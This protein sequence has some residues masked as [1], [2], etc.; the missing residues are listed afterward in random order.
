[1]FERADRPR[2]F[3]LPPGADFPRHLVDGLLERT[4]G[5]PPEVLGRTT[6]IVNTRR[7]ARRIRSLFDA[8]PALLLP[9]IRLV[10]DLGETFALG[11]IPAPVPLLRRRLMLVQ[12]VQAL[13]DREPDLAPRAALYDLADSLARVFEEMR[14]EGVSFDAIRRIDVSGHSDHWARALRF[15]TIVEQIEGGGAAPDPTARL[16]MVAEHLA[17]SWPDAPPPGPVIV[18]G[19]TGSRGATSLLMQAVAR[20]PQGAVVLPGYDFDL[21]EPVWLDQL[22]DPLLAED[23][24]QYRFRALT[25][26]LGLS[27]GEVAAWTG[28]VQNDARNRLVSLALRPAPVTDQWLAEGPGQDPATAMAGVTLVEAP[29][30]REEAQTIALRLR[31]AAED[32]VRAALITPDRLLARQ[33]TA[34]LTRWDILPDDSAG[35][36][37][38]LTPPGRFLRQVAALSH[39]RGGAAGLLALL[40][41]PLCHT[42]AERGTHLLL[43]RALEAELRREGPP[44]PDAGTLR[45]FAADQPDQMARDWADWAGGCAI[46]GEDAGPRPLTQ[47]VAELIARADRLAAGCAAEGSGRL[48]EGTDGADVRAKLAELAGAAEVAGDIGAED[49]TTLV[50][51]IL[52]GAEQRDSSS[53]HPHISIWGTLQ[54]RVQG[55]DLVI[56]GGLNEGSWPEAAAPDPWL[57]RAMRAEVGLLLPERRIG[58]S[59][60]DFQQ[61]IAAPE[62][63]ITRALRGSEAETVASRWL[64]RI[65]NLLSGLGSVGQAALEGSRARGRHW[66]GLVAALDAVDPV[67]PAPRPARRRAAA[68]AVGHA[69]QDADPRPLCDLRAGG[70]AAAASRPADEGS[71]CA[72]AGDRQ[73]RG[74]GTVR[75]RG[76]GRPGRAAPRSS[77]GADPRGAGAGGALGGGAAALAGPDGAGGGGRGWRRGRAAGDGAARGL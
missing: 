54:A 55:A 37:L 20:L 32:G 57:N 42:G 4:A 71:G 76:D 48:W 50:T 44:F 69:G 6:L 75:Q 28:S 59:A 49:F 40:K 46:A 7:M 70:A 21:P 64:N 27:P 73:P 52:A 5:L 9:R 16:R 14:G 1:M 3:G 17:A 26:A 2:V 15:L 61:A 68:K 65:T 63:W 11:T 31:Q 34:A 45:A 60:H 53:P 67:A 35:E 51:A 8:G 66:L 29:S 41:H 47:R 22:S 12:L 58:L 19:S 72:D 56:L 62:V 10:T 39:D 30:A 43:T 24:P 74:A 77:C 38:H 33:V 23:H 36:P 13:I 25:A 18:A